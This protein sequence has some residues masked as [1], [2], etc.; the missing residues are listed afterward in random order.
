MFLDKLFKKK[1]EVIEE[2]RELDE[3]CFI[4]EKFDTGSNYYL[5]DLIY[6]SDKMLIEELKLR[7][8]DYFMNIKLKDSSYSKSKIFIP[9]ELNREN[10]LNYIK[11]FDQKFDF[12][13]KIWIVI[14]TFKGFNNNNL[15]WVFNETKSR[16]I[17][18]GDEFDINNINEYINK[19][20]ELNRVDP[21][22]VRI[23]DT[24]TKMDYSLNYDDNYNKI[25]NLDVNLNKINEINNN[26][27][28][29]NDLNEENNLKR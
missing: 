17:Y 10:V 2:N 3:G 22:N 20:N 27:E 13:N 9:D 29:N 28:L 6:K 8:Y 23:I 25:N 12:N 19:I 26:E 24:K 11:I 5:N 1:E 21:E 18:I 15:Y 14:F 7:T 4:L 16:I